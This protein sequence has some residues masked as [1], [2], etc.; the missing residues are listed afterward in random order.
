MKK[1]IYRVIEGDTLKSV[2]DFLNI[3]ESII[4]ELNNL[5]REIEKGDLLFVEINKSSPLYLVKP[6]DTLES[7]AKSFCVDK[8]EILDLNFIPYV[9]M[10]QKILIPK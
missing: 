9:Y 10:G 7:I 4:I 3:P 6:T 8:K 1:L 2:S 5:S